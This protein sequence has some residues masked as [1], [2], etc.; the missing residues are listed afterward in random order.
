MREIVECVLVAAV[1]EA[2][3][4]EKKSEWVKWE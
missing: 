1:C 3:Q 2:C 4:C